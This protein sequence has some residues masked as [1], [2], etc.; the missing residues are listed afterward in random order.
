VPPKG[1]PDHDGRVL[2]PALEALQN[3]LAMQAQAVADASV[4]AP[5]SPE[6]AA[7]KTRRPMTAGAAFGSASK[8][9]GVSA[10]VAMGH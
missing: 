10:W 1:G 4:G 8:K 3:L 6:A 2:L 7:S 9:K 5:G